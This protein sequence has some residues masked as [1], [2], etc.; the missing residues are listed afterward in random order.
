[1]SFG[2]R[3]CDS[4]FEDFYVQEAIIDTW[5]DDGIVDQI[6]IEL[7][8]DLDIM[9]IFLIGIIRENMSFVSDSLVRLFAHFCYYSYQLWRKNR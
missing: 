2:C 4:I 9:R 6:T 7:D 1:M 8:S 3:K 5:Y